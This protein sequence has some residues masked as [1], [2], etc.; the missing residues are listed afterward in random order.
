MQTILYDRL[1]GTDKLADLTPLLHNDRFSTAVPGLYRQWSAEIGEDIVEMFHWFEE[2]LGC[3]LIVWANEEGE[4]CVW[5]G[6]LWNVRLSF[7]GTGLTR[8]LGDVHNRV[9]V[10]YSDLLNNNRYSL[11]AWAN[12]ADSQDTYGIKEHV[13]SPGGLTAAMAVNVRDTFAGVHATPVVGAT[14]GIP[15]NQAGM[16][17]SV[18]ALG[19][20]ATLRY[21]LYQRLVT[22]TATVQAILEDIVDTTIAPAYGTSYVE[23][24]DPA[25]LSLIGGTNLNIT[26]YEDNANPI[27]DY[28]QH[29][30]SLGDNSQNIWYVGVETGR[31]QGPVWT[32]PRLRVWQ[33]PETPDFIVSLADTLCQDA[34]GAARSILA[35][36]AGMMVLI[37]DLVPDAASLSTP[38]DQLRGFVLTET[39]YNAQTGELRGTP[40]G[41]D[42]PLSLLLARMEG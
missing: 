21:R 38:L 10:E 26:Q 19:Y 9:A 41:S 14:I 27:Q 37:R 12:D 22:T 3:R 30:V 7:G 39:E 15:V 6:L 18:S 16:R 42:A 31:R 34:G 28:I 5:D 11:T 35:I 40:E 13:L 20:W 32:L 33:R 4:E 17:L 24:L 23:F 25:D 1:P 36:Q 8:S 29:V 2:R